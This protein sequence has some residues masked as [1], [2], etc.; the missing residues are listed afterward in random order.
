M[1]SDEDYTRDEMGQE[2]EKTLATVHTS[3]DEARLAMLV[4]IKSVLAGVCECELSMLPASV[5]R[6]TCAIMD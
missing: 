5:S 3:V 2:K 6:S 4:S 1:V